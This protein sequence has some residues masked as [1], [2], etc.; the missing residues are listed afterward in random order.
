M[1]SKTIYAVSR[2]SYSDY[3]IVALFSTAADA[4]LFIERHPDRWSEWNDIETYD[5][6]SGV[7]KMRKGFSHFMVQ[8]KRD[9]TITNVQ[10]YP[11]AIGT[12]PDTKFRESRGTVVDQPWFNWYGWARD[13]VH[14]VKSANEHRISLA[15][16]SG[17][18]LDGD[19]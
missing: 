1:K 16:G 19:V 9:G 11:T 13:S 6:D 3:G 17:H 4:A 2:G 15:A 12:K 14:A 8:M 10:A 18:Q 5:L 7:E